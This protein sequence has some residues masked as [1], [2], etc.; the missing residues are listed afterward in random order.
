MKILLNNQS[1]NAFLDATSLNIDGVR[2]DVEPHLCSSFLKKAMYFSP[3][4]ESI[5]LS[6][7]PQGVAREFN[8]ILDS[9]LRSASSLDFE[10]A[11][12]AL[13]ALQKA[14]LIVREREAVERAWSETV[15]SML[16]FTKNREKSLVSVLASQYRPTHIDGVGDKVA[17]TQFAQA[18]RDEQGPKDYHFFRNTLFSLGVQNEREVLRLWNAPVPH[19]Y[20]T[21]SYGFASMAKNEIIDL[22]EKIIMQAVK[23][24]LSP[25]VDLPIFGAKTAP[26]ASLPMAK[27]RVLE[28]GDFSLLKGKE[29]VAARGGGALSETA[30]NSLGTIYKKEVALLKER[31]EGFSAALAS[32]MAVR[33]NG[34]SQQGLLEW[35]KYNEENS[36]LGPTVAYGVAIGAVRHANRLVDCGILATENGKDFSFTC[37]LAREALLESLEGDNHRYEWLADKMIGFLRDAKT[38]ASI[39]ALDLPLEEGYVY[40]RPEHINWKEEK[41]KIS[42]LW[43]K[44]QSE[45][46][47]RKGADLDAQR[48]F[49]NIGAVM[50]EKISGSDLASWRDK[51]TGEGWRDPAVAQAFVEASLAQ[52]KF[53]ASIG[54]MKEIAD[55]EFEFVD[56]Y[57]REL[58]YALYRAENSA[59]VDLSRGIKAPVAATTVSGVRVNPELLEGQREEYRAFLAA[60]FTSLYAPFGHGSDV[61]MKDVLEKN[62][63][64]FDRFESLSELRKAGLDNAGFES[65]TRSV[66]NEMRDSGAFALPQKMATGGAQEEKALQERLIDELRSFNFYWGM[67][68]GESYRRQMEAKEASLLSEVGFLVLRDSAFAERVGELFDEGALDSAAAQ[69]FSACGVSLNDGIDFERMPP[70]D[71]SGQGAYWYLH[72]SVL[73]TGMSTPDDQRKLIEIFNSFYSGECDIDETEGAIAGFVEDFNNCLLERRAQYGERVASLLLSEKGQACEQ[74]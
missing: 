21:A 19:E 68:S 20:D 45:N 9:A 5:E 14:G 70:L 8:A 43:K 64:A 22:Q 23:D 74:L 7:L 13:V 48:A 35:A 47:A 61:F 11:Q 63:S 51:A 55:G 34:L 29:S 28:R 3:H 42:E 73:G 59:L 36:I 2:L 54:I 58:V 27:K 65:V 50:R 66:L 67:S 18:Y 69:A 12:E 30:R 37:D 26:L 60:E 15:K 53:F 46:S 1:V 31:G 44:A 40:A 10:K 32:A 24:G 16:L 57:A 56:G 39:D 6:L 49:I 17:A 62:T 33:S 25:P 38:Q 4:N 72:R 71:T 52:A 41:N